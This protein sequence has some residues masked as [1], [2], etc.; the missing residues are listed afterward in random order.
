MTIYRVP[1]RAV[2]IGSLRFTAE[3]TQAAIEEWSAGAS[4]FTPRDSDA[5]TLDCDAARHISSAT[6]VVVVAPDGR[7]RAGMHRAIRYAH[8]MRV[9]V[10]YWSGAEGDA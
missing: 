6:H 5:F 8:R 9:P 7:I 4:V 2:I 1:R 3:I 10:R